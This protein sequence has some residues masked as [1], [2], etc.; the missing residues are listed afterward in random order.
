MAGGL[1]LLIAG[2]IVAGIALLGR[3]GK[4]PRNYFVGI[5]LP[6][7]MRSDEAWVA[8]HRVAWPYILVTAILITISGV[9]F[10]LNPDEPP[11]EWVLITVILVPLVIGAVR[12]HLVARRLP[13]PRP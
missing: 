2:V 3:V 8:A 6:S 11:A 9:F 10:L 4:L 1:V 12:A 13:R 5:R 7:T